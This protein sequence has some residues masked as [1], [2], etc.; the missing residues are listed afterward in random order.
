MFLFQY[1]LLTSLMFETYPVAAD[2]SPFSSLGLPTPSRLH[3]AR[4]DLFERLCEYFPRAMTHP[5]SNLVELV[6]CPKVSLVARL[7]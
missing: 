7:S 5:R 4:N 3:K 6:P 2:A 1:Q